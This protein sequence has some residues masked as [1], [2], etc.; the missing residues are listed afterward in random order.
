MISV[1]V[2]AYNEEAGIAQLYERLTTAATDWDEDYEILLVNDGS[3]DGTLSACAERAALD[4][5][6]KVICL[7]RNFGHQ[8]AITAGLQHAAGDLVAIIDADLQDPPE[9]LGRFFAK[10]REGYDVVY[11]VRTK[12]KETLLKRACYHA[13]YRAL[14]ALA[15]ID[16]PLDAGD[17]CV[18]SRRAVDMLN[19]LPERNRFVRGLRTWIG[20]RQI[21]L[22]YE[23][24]PRAAGEPKYT[25]GKLVN[26]AF[27]GIINFSYKPL[28][29]ITIAGAL[30]GALAFVFGA[31]FFVQYVTDTSIFGY[32]PRAARGW[33]SIILAVL[34]LSG[35]QLL[36]LGIL[37]EYIGRL[38]EETKQR[39]LF[40]VGSTL[41]MEHASRSH[42][43]QQPSR[44]SGRVLDHADAYA[45]TADQ[46]LASVGRPD[47]T[48]SDRI[49]PNA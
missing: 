36:S 23:R 7:A 37:G 30:V 8:A 13:Y 41:N 25:F 28:R 5:R 45:Q 20:F 40:V 3:C 1:V 19:A 12:R 15:T 14:S 26:L 46:F 2:P 11:A 6:F 16:I 29:V 35:T 39:P 44:T 27:D 17:F 34:L 22:R 43:Q 31:I 4:V 48:E 24:Q 47:A 10:C 42:W 9:E 21:G 33:T 38:F 32:N 18:L 49:S